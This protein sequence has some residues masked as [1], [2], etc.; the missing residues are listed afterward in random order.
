MKTHASKGEHILLAV[1]K[2]AKKWS[3]ARS[4]ASCGFKLNAANIWTEKVGNFF[5]KVVVTYQPE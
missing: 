4:G 3:F 1:R 2:F 5:L